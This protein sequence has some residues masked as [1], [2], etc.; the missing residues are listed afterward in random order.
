[1]S[2][3]LMRRI[4][5]DHVRRLQYQKRGGQAARVT[6][7]EN[8]MGGIQRASDLVALDDALNRLAELD[9]RKAQ[10]VELKFF[11]GLSIDETAEVLAISPRTVK[12]EWSLAQAWLYSELS[13]EGRPD[14]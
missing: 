10:V 2:A 7:D 1:V 8:V 3:N 14:V 6:F 4:L 5:V 12:R 13:K 11:G 9:P